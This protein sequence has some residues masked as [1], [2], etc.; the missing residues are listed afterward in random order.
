MSENPS[1]PDEVVGRTG[2]ALPEHVERAVA[3]AKAAFPAWR[4]T[5]AER[6]VEILRKAAQI[7][8]ERRFELAA[9]IALENGKPWR[10]ADGDVTEAIDF[11]EWYSR[12]ALR[13]A[14]PIR[15]AGL[16]G[17]INHYMYEPRGVA[18]VIAPWNFPLAILTGM[19]SAALWWRAMRWC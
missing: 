13:L 15:M 2:R 12:V 11:I 16:T 18:A 19:S 5:P 7:M 8:R 9:L 4:D 1:K 6:R 14:R 17:E 3:A 10:E